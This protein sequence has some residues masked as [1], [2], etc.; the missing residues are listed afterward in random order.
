VEVGDI[1]ALAGAA[2]AA[3]AAAAVWLVAVVVAVVVAAVSAFVTDVIASAL[4]LARV[5]AQDKQHNGRFG[6]RSSVVNEEAWTTA[7]ACTATTTRRWSW[8]VGKK[9][10]ET[11]TVVNHNMD[12]LIMQESE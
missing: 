3:A 5:D 2:A 9:G 11:A 8:V 1:G 6:W 10:A 7:E 12:Y 4:V